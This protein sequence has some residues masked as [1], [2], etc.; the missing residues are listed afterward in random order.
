MAKVKLLFAVHSH[1]P[2]GNFEG[3]FQEAY[4]KA[5][6]P[7]LDTI[8]RYPQVKLSLHYSGAL[9]DWLADKHPDF[10]AKINSLI[11]QGRLEIL[12][13]GYYE[14]IVSI[15]PE[16]DALGQIGLLRNR[17]K[18]LFSFDV[19]GAWLVERIWEPRVAYILSKSNISYTIVDDSHFKFIA[20]DPDSLEGYYISEDQGMPVS[21]FPGSEKLR[22]LLPFR[23]PQE[24]ID[25]LRHRQ[26]RAKQDVAIT[27]A[28][29]GEKF[30]LW[31][32]THKWVYKE[33]WLENFLKLLEANRDWIEFQTFSDY[34]KENPA[35]GK[36][37]LKCASYREML[38]WSQGYF[39]NFFIKYS[40]ADNMHKKMFYVSQKLKDAAPL[41][42]KEDFKRAQNFLYKGQAND[43][44]WHGVF[45][46]LYLNHLRSGVYSNLIESEKISD[47]AILKGA[48]N[49][50]VTDIN[51][52]SDKE[53]IIE[54]RSHNLVFLPH[55]QGALFEWDYKPKAINLTNTIMRRPEKYHQRLSEK[56]NTA[57]NVSSG[58]PSIHEMGG[59]LEE[60]LAQRLQYDRCLR[61]SL[62]ERF[63]S[64]ETTLDSFISSRFQDE[65][66]PLSKRCS[67]RVVS[68]KKQPPA[69]EFSYNALLNGVSVDIIKN[70][71]VKKEI[72]AGYEI[73]KAKDEDSGLLFGIE[74]NF[75]LY[76][77]NLC[78]NKG[79]INARSLD[80]EDIWYGINLKFDLNREACIWHFPVETISDS[81]AGIERAYQEMCLVFLWGL[82]EAAGSKLSID[83][84]VR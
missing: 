20:E 82:D 24:T 55:R 13:G 33:G 23:L 9:L 6:L 18:E 63:I 64:K 4:E 45:G 2:V 52:D 22:Y 50:A 37:Y 36:I 59:V 42:K 46:G 26:G 10:L 14:P 1:Q 27:F 48:D 32:G 30:G 49:I 31:P 56:L 66:A 68:S 43:S 75:S 65:L 57:D 54:T 60:G 29:D 74:F 21:I 81:E 5:Y 67:Y 17:I 76:D 78:R 69:V 80:V 19:K 40:E 41:L 12:G 11:G 70:V 28:D 62:F 47:K 73:K 3:V 44:Y 61:Y 51:L 39:R 16:A 84:S 71:C 15:I 72:R 34:I 58:I 83:I 38:E 25:Y 77:P 8:S 7:F 35:T 79:S 53:I